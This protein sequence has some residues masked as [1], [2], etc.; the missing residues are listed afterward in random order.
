MYPLRHAAQLF[1]LMLDV[2]RLDNSQNFACIRQIKCEAQHGNAVLYWID[3]RFLWIDFH[4]QRLQ[5][6]LDCFQAAFQV[7]FVVGNNHEIVHIAQII[8]SMQP[9]LYVMVDWIQHGD[10][11]NLYHL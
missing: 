9:F 1:P 5:L 3:P 10:A 6:F 11:K 8:A 4:M 2:F 7:V